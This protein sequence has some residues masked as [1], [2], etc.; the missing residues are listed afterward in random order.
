MALFVDSEFTGHAGG[1]LKFKIECDALSDEDIETIASIIA[2]SYTFRSVHGIPRGGLRLAK[3]LQKHCSAE[4][5]VLIVDD[6]L[7]S[8]ASMEEA[9][10]KIGSA[11]GIV[12]FARG[13]RPNWVKAV[14]ELSAWAGP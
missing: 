9:K 5:S 1:K 12:I 2:R 4:G 10:K 3:A 14:F 7:T 6:V 13:I 8:G 11:I